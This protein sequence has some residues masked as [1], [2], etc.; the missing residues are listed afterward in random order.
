MPT[1]RLSAPEF[2]HSTLRPPQPCRPR[3]A[4]ATCMAS[5]NGAAGAAPRRKLSPATLVVH[6]EGYIDDPYASSMPP[7]Y[8]TATFGQPGATEMGEYDYTRSGNPTRTALERQMA[9]LEGADRSL[10][11]TSGMAALAAVTR[12]CS[13][14]DHI[15]AGDDL[16]GGT[17]RLLSRVVPAAGV[18]V[19]NVDTSDVA[20][21]AAAIVPGRTRLV[22]LESP[23]NPRMQICDLAA[24]AAAARA[25][26]AW[27]CVDNSIMCP[28]FQRPLD[29]GAD[30]CMTSAT[31]FVG[32]HADVMAGV[33]SVRGA[34]LA[35][36][37]A[38]VQ[39]A[40]GA[41]L[42]PFDCWLLVRGLKT[43]ALRMERA[44]AS[45]QRIAEWLEAHPSVAAV[46][47]PGLAAH[48]GRDIHFRQVGRG[49][50]AVVAVVL[51]LLGCVRA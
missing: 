18:S 24:V 2:S 30:I 17:S 51:L 20:A 41:A 39:N 27:V 46:N 47:F 23:T 14:G 43:M 48:P 33:L 11:F 22:M 19:T 34:E 10:A 4:P 50:R 15:L 45:A 44:A 42:A 35:E 6:S 38:F 37:L 12:L 36:R 16:Y 26:G 9:A 3:A 29:L 5:G 8:Q 25:A 49:A 7:L 13:A 40:E 1:A 21:V 31:K 28:L 32:G